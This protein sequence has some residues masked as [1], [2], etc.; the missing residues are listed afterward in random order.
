MF[1]KPGALD[2]SNDID[3]TVKKLGIKKDDRNLFIQLAIILS[4]A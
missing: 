2:D 1:K 3:W 4:A